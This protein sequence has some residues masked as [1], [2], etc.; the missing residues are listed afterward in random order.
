M[1]SEKPKEIK[2]S[3]PKLSNF[4]K[5]NAI[6]LAELNFI[7]AESL[8][9]FMQQEGISLGQSPQLP[10]HIVGG[11]EELKAHIDYPHWQL[12]CEWISEVQEECVSHFLKGGAQG[13]ALKEWWLLNNAAVYI[14]NYLKKSTDSGVYAVEWLSQGY[15]ILISS[16]GHADYVLVCQFV[17]ALV[18]GYL[19]KHK[20]AKLLTGTRTPSPTRKSPGGTIKPKSGKKSATPVQAK[21]GAKGGKKD[22]KDNGLNLDPAVVEDI[23]KAIQISETVY[24]QIVGKGSVGLQ[25]R[26]ALLCQ[27]VQCKQVMGQPLKT[28]L[29]DEEKTDDLSVCCK[30]I[31]AVEMSN[32]NTNGYYVFPNTPSMQEAVKMVDGCTWSDKLIELEVWTKMASLALNSITATLWRAAVEGLPNYRRKTQR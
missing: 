7:Y 16:R 14:W 19:T 20:V 21:G 26:K 22:P 30:S 27:W 29:P 8:I 10:R 25:K 12:Y 15:N 31:V 2:P 3:K 1:K 23:T 6:L 32:L 5:S 11:E 13:V 17:E 9:Y 28:L 24:S 18:Q 4:T